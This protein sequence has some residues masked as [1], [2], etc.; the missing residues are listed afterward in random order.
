MENI[1][2]SICVYMYVIYNPDV[3]DKVVRYMVRQRQNRFE[4]GQALNHAY[5]LP[6]PQHV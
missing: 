1:H 5:M 6:A 4:Y 2:K 3:V